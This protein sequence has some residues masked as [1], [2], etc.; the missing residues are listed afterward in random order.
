MR[1]AV[2]GGGSIGLRHVRNLL[3]LGVRPIDL[4]VC[5]PVWGTAGL[6]QLAEEYPQLLIVRAPDERVWTRAQA[7]VI[8]TPWAAHLRYAEE[9]VGRGLPV[10]VEKPLG[11]LDQLDEWRRLADRAV[12]SKVVTQVGYQLRFHPKARAIKA[13]LP[14]ADSGQFYLDC[15]GRT[16]PGRHYGPMLLE[17]SHE[18]DLALWLGAPATVD[19]VQRDGERAVDIWL[20]P[21]QGD[22]WRVCLNWQADRYFRQWSVTQDS[23]RGLPFIA[24]DAMHFVFETPEALGDQMY[25]DEMAYFLR[26][27]EAGRP[28]DCCFV[29]AL[30]VLEVCAQV[31]RMRA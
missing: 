5:D 23:R 24:G 27:V 28:T 15:D 18:I 19:E 14:T 9:A 2:I 8:A 3:G 22:G 17:C 11:S 6:Q 30:R 7:V 1:V 26:A 12:G 31:E 25:V 20:G 13:L 29:D 4:V 21:Q 10:F 16:W